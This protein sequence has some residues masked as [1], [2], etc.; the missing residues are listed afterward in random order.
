MSSLEIGGGLECQEESLSVKQDLS[1]QLIYA[2]VYL[3]C[4]CDQ[5][6]SHVRLF[7]FPRTIDCK[8]PP[9][10]EFSRQEY[11]SGLPCPPPGNLSDPGI[12]PISFMSPALAGRFFTTSTTWESPI[13]L[14]H[15]HLLSTYCASDTVSDD[16]N[17]AKSNKQN[18]CP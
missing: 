9:P 11:W 17:T 12:E 16:R 6:L 18:P 13:C 1:L 4:L 7:A 2:L 5:L 8:A 10:K 3:T 15:E 14:L